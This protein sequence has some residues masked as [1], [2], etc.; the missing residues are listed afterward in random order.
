MNANWYKNQR[1]QENS[2]KRKVLD[3]LANYKLQK[4]CKI[5]GYN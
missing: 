4:G 5:C 2:R 1:A 3:F